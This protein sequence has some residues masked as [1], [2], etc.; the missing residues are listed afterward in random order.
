[1]GLYGLSKCGPLTQ[2]K[3]RRTKL[4]RGRIFPEKIFR[5]LRA[6]R[7]LL[8]LCY[9]A[10]KSS[11]GRGLEKGGD[12]GD[13][14][15]GPEEDQTCADD[16]LAPPGPVVVDAVVARAELAMPPAVTVE[17]AKGF[18]LYMLKAILSGRGDEIVELA[19]TNLRR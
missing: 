18:S 12:Q 2:H 19:R 16:A 8:R 17:M 13:G 7:L 1:M 14:E 15:L 6:T 11:L 10:W 5:A 3:Q 4:P 9:G